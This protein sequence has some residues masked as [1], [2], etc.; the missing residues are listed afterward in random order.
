LNEEQ[1][2]IMGSEQPQSTGGPVRSLA[3]SR[4]WDATKG[5]APVELLQKGFELAYFIITDRSSALDILVRALDKVRVRSHR[6]LK[7]LYWRDKHSQ[8][9]VRRIARTDA[10]IL[11]WLIMFESEKDERAQEGAGNVPLR[12]MAIRYVKHLVQIT[13]ASSSFYVNVGL[14]RL[15]HSYSTPEAQR[16]Y[17]ML[18]SR[19]LGAD[20]YRRAK[21]ALMDKINRRFSGLLRVARVEHGELRFELAHDQDQWVKVIADSLSAF[22]PWSTHGRCAQF[23]T[24]NGGNSKPTSAYKP[25]D[26]DQNEAEMGCCHILIEPS[27]YGRLMKELAFDSPDR[28]LALPRFVMPENH[29]QSD[30]RMNQSTRPPGLSQKDL[31]HIERRLAATDARRRQMNPR[32]ITI[33][34][35][36][37]EHTRLDLAQRAQVEI[38][39]EAGASLIEIRGEDDRGE[40]LLASH[41][42]S[43]EN[44]AFEA[45]RATATLRSGK[46]KFGITPIATLGL[47]PPRAILS[48]NYQP[49]FQL[50]RPSIAWR[51]I[52]A[53][54]KTIRAYALAA[55]FTGVIGW[56]V[57]GAFYAHRIRVLEQQLQEAHGNPQKVLPTAARA[58][59]SYRLTPDDQTVR[60]G[61]TSGVPEI[62]LRPHPSAISLELPLPKAAAQAESYIAELKTFGGDQTLIT[63]N[64]LRAKTTDSGPVIELVIPADLLKVGTYYTVL[65]HSSDRTDHFTF[66]VVDGQ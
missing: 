15:L 49:K 6:E 10:D 64:F 5:A 26:R 54:G 18:T 30:E 12:S 34:I 41:L 1:N 32:M 23:I 16:V 22:T 40:L 44:N 56:A 19:F 62:S 8:R 47:G 4:P 38:G 13:T 63:Q 25:S 35:D 57:A 46:L 55:L 43:Y 52:K 61:G 60:G 39:L 20:E 48:I 33:A 14:S 17:E 65:L 29:D 58:I 21:S 2:G 42:I 31:D 59:L 51:R 45:T 27:C 66:T 36:G 50:T 53:S 3:A 11:Q 9:P 37:M 24:V 7:R 28:K